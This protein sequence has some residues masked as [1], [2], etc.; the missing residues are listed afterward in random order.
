MH[1]VK[2]CIM[3]NVTENG[4]YMGK[5]GKKLITCQSTKKS[6]GVNAVVTVTYSMQHQQKLYNQ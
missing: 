6:F 1:C 2:K 3:G 5:V 4:K